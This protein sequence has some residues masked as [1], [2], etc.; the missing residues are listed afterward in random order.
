[1]LHSCHSQLFVRHAVVAISALSISKNSMEEGHTH[2]KF[3]YAKYGS[4]VRGMRKHL[5]KAGLDLRMTLIA[6]LLVCCFEILD[7]HYFIAL[8]HAQNGINLLSEWIKQHPHPDPNFQGIASP[9]ALVIEDALVQAFLR[10]DLLVLNFFDSRQNAVHDIMKNEG[11]TTIKKMPSAFH[12]LDEARQYLTLIQ[13]RATH[14]IYSS[15][16]AA[17]REIALNLAEWSHTENVD[18]LQDYPVISKQLPELY[19]EQRLY[20]QD[21]LRWETA[22]ESLHQKPQHTGNPKLFLRA[23]VFLARSLTVRIALTSI[24]DTDCCAYDDHYADF[25]RIVDLSPPIIKEYYKKRANKALHFSLEND[26][27]P[28]LHTMA[29]FCRD[30]VLR[31][32]AISL[33]LEMDC[34]EGGW[35]SRGFALMDQELMEAEE[36]G[37]DTYDSNNS[38]PLFHFP[39]C[40]LTEALNVYLN[41]SILLRC[42]QPRSKTTTILTSY[43]TF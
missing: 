3:A 4:A 31:R 38:P 30:R 11:V 1:M 10:L 24:L 2:A 25:K 34:S 7:G 17:G 13:A 33:L 21:C 5:V 23:N 29:R 22:F 26:L 42:R 14:F 9:D 37:I 18:K 15:S 39:S 41:R 12:S 20:V 40:H 32:E 27:L 28:C 6:C 16:N 19:N 43:S 35:D 36:A 8:V